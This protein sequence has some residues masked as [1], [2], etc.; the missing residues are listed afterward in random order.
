MKKIIICVLSMMMASASV[1]NAEVRREGNTFTQV[2]E[3]KQ[4]AEPTATTYKYT[5]KDGKEYPIYLSKNGRAYILRVS[6]KGN[7]YR[8]YL[9]E[10]ISKTICKEL[11]TEYVEKTK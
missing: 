3:S 4:K 1:M 8:Q 2:S 5:T 11:G 6:A 9:G 10:E 7:E